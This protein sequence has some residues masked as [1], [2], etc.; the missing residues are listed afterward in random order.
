MQKFGNLKVVCGPMFSGKTE[1]VQRLVRRAT[2][3]KK[4]VCVLVP[5]YD[6][7]YGVGRVKS[8]A[9]RTLSEAPVYAVHMDNPEDWLSYIK[10]M[11]LVVFDEVQ[12][13][14]KQLPLFIDV[15]LEKGIDVVVAGLDLDFQGKPF[16]SMPELLAQADE[17]IKLKA[18]CCICGVDANRTYRTTLDLNLVLLGA[19]ESYQARCATCWSKRSSVCKKNME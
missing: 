4:K 12:F 3:A 9:N 16:G 11:D 19:E 5:E 18:V 2:V 6:N 17:V 8:H 14:S 1:E 10:N 7:R 15:I 13:F